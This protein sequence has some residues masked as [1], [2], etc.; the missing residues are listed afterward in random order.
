M[1]AR[2][3]ARG[4]RRLQAV[5]GPAPEGSACAT[6]PPRSI[7]MGLAG[8]LLGTG[9]GTRPRRDHSPQAALG[10]RSTE[11]KCSKS[12][13]LSPLNAGSP[14]DQEK[15]ICCVDDCFEEVEIKKEDKKMNYTHNSPICNK[16]FVAYTNEIYVSHLQ[17][18]QHKQNEA[19][20]KGKNDLSLLKITEIHNICSE[21]VDGNGLCRISNYTGLKKAELLEKMNAIYDY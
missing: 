3:A 12:F 4:A 5:A 9:L 13:A 15:A 10:L 19:T 7:A 20:L 11:L 1:P 18:I 14:G 2:A 17:S 21:T 16:S 6:A 8:G